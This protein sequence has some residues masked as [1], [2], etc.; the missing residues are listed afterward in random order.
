MQQ[1]CTLEVHYSNLHP[2]PEITVHGGPA[3]ECTDR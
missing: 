1:A 3:Q 2:A